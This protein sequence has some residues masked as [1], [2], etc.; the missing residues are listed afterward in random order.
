M[1]DPPADG[2]FAAQFLALT[3]DDFHNVERKPA[4][5]LPAPN[6]GGFQP[7][8]ND[9]E[10]FP[11]VLGRRSLPED[12]SNGTSSAGTTKESHRLSKRYDVCSLSYDNLNYPST[13]RVGAAV[14]NQHADN[15]PLITKWIDYG[16]NL[17]AIPGA[18]KWL[19]FQ[20]PGRVGTQEYASAFVPS[21]FIELS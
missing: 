2:S 7:W 15:N 16:F 12:R 4:V 9:P 19:L 14:T 13:A 20:Y 21:N 11:R 5:F 10:D 3:D 6:A 17:G 1:P 8:T 18:C